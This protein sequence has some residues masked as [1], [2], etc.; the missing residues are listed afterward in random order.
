MFDNTLESRLMHP[1][2]V[3]EFEWGFRPTILAT[4]QHQIFLWCY[5]LSLVVHNEITK[6]KS[7][8]PTFT[9]S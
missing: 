7:F 2:I 3:I 9:V 5:S 4:L 1:L 6:L 8:V